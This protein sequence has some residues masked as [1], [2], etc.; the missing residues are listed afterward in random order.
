M[1]E[2]TAHVVRVEG[3]DAWVE[4][5]RRSGCAGCGAAGGCGVGVLSKVL[6]RRDAPLRVSSNQPLQPG[7]EVIIGIDESALV[8]AS[9]AVY[10]VPLVLMLAGAALGVYARSLGLVEGEGLTVLLGALGFGA[11]VGWL[12]RYTRRVRCSPRFQPVVLRRAVPVAPSASVKNDLG[13]Q[14]F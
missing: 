7:D 5:G 3:Q 11:G 9:L 13:S 8:Q 14:E 10:L 2:E 12:G 4:T 1:L 6:G